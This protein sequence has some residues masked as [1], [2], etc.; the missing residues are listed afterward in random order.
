VGRSRTNTIHNVAQTQTNLAW[1]TLFD[2][3]GQPA[4]ALKDRLARS[5]RA[6]IRDGRLPR[7]AALPPSR[8]LATDLGISRWAVTQAYGQLVTE[9]Y[10]DARTGSATR[11]AWS[12]DPEDR[13]TRPVRLREQAGPPRYDLSMWSPDYRAFPRRKWVEAIRAEAETVPYYQLDYGEPGGEPKLRAI[14]AEHLNRGRGAHAEPGSLSV[15]SGA[16]QSMGQISRAL[17]LAGYK[18]IGVESPGSC[19]LWEPARNAGLETVPLPA[20]EGGLI[21][22]AL[23]DHPGLR[24]VC[25]GAA[26]QILYGTPLAPERRAAL[27]DWAR[28]ADG[29]IIEDD[30]D[31]EF[32][33]DGPA[34]PVIQGSDFRRVALLGSMS[35]SMTPTVN[36]GWILAPPR[37]VAAVRTAYQPAL[38][39]PALTQLAL[40]SLM[41]SGGYDRHLRAS[42]QRLRTRRNALVAALGRELPE[43][44]VRAPQGGLHVLLELPGSID[45]NA[46]VAVARPAGMDLCAADDYLSEPGAA[47]LPVLPIGYGNLPDGLIHEAVALLAT[48]IKSAVP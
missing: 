39:P 43:Y 23:D 3:S 26:R 11:V 24:L 31:A 38:T 16:R 12:P 47:P 34:P 33:Y 32:S 41:E 18:R 13:I 22:A 40:A 20:D 30:Y 10:L 21:T 37:W 8:T 19:G 36:V 4:G 29:L 46:I 7:G 6:A 27:L 1:E 14:L 5:I 44:P 48:L 28:R 17:F 25:V 9:G 45:P 35:R 15:F 2:V 42:R